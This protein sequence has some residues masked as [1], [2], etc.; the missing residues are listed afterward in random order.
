MAKKD[1]Y[2]YERHSVYGRVRLRRR[3]RSGKDGRTYKWWEYD[4][5]FTPEIPGYA[6]PGDPTKQVFC[7]VHQVPKYFYLDEG[8]SCVECGNDFVFTATE[9][10]FWYETLKFH[11]DSVAIRC[12][13]CRRRQRHQAALNA[14]V[15]AARAAV[16]RT[17]DSPTGYLDVAE[18]LVR[19]HQRT[20]CGNLND[21]IDAA[22]EARTQWP[23]CVESD[24]WEG[25]AHHLA[26]RVHR[27]EALLQRFL[28]Q[29]GSAAVRRGSLVREARSIVGSVQHAVSA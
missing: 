17:P 25:I 15:A 3:S 11:F 19:L 14:Q 7:A 26:G 23:E 8:R 13:A 29:P 5:T 18:S 20:G 4:P 22:R 1:E 27:A 21:A 24:F 12:R 10:R 6:V 9:Q 28:K 2:T 16:A